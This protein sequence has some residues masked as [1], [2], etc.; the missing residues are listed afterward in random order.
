M[1]LS[2][3]QNKIANNRIDMEKIKLRSLSLSTL[4]FS[5]YAER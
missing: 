1:H 4:H 3:F 5:S 2:S